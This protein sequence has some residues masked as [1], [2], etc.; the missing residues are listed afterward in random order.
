MY[1]YLIFL[2][3]KGV[4]NWKNGDRYEGDFINNKLHGFGIFYFNGENANPNWNEYMSETGEFSKIKWS[5]GDVYEGEFR[6]GKMTG[7]GYV[8]DKYGNQ[9]YPRLNH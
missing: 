9:I 2:L 1:L 6:N 3:S 8:F 4:F 7:N 5:W